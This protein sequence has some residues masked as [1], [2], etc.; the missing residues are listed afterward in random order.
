MVRQRGGCRETARW[1]ARTST[2]RRTT[3]TRSRYKAALG[4]KKLVIRLTAKT[5]VVSQAEAHRQPDGAV[6]QDRDGESEGVE[7]QQG[8]NVDR[9]RDGVE[10]VADQGGGKGEEGD[11]Q[12]PAE[13]EQGQPGDI[14]AVGFAHR[15]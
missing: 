8:R 9:T 11:R 3:S 5:T 13:V 7:H 2:A 6:H 10:V 1:N 12:E 14:V 4:L 15:R